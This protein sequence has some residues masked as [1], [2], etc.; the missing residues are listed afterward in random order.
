[1]M[2]SQKQHAEVKPEHKSRRKPEPVDAGLLQTDNVSVSGETV[3]GVMDGRVEN[4]AAWLRNK[5]VQAVQ[6]TSLA[7]YIGH[8]QGNRHLRGVVARVATGKG[9]PQHVQRSPLSD[10]LT[11]IWTNQPKGIFFNR[12]RNLNV[13]DPDVLSA[14][15][16][17]LSG[18]DLWLARNLINYGPEASWPIHL[19]VEREMK[20]WADCRGKGEVFSILR[21]AAGAEASN[22]D[23]TAVLNRIFPAGSDDLWLASNLQ[24]HGLEASWPIHLR[25]EREMKGWADC[26]GKGEVFTILRNAAGADSGNA[27]L[28]AVL[29]RIFTAGSDDLWVA[30]NLQQYG[31][32]ANWPIHLRVDR[33]MKGWAD[34]HGKGEV[35]TILRNAAGAEAGNADLTSTLDRLFAAGSEDRIL[36]N[37]LQQYG[38][39]ASWPAPTA[40]DVIPFDR[41]PNSSPGERIIMS[42]EY[43]FPLADNYHKLVYSCVGGGFDAAGGANNKTIQGLEAINQNFFIDAAWTGASPVTVTLQV[44][45]RSNNH[46]ALSETWT[47]AK[48]ARFPTTINQ[49]EAEG[50]RAL[51]STYSYKVGPDLGGDL[52]TDYEHQTILERFEHRTC[53]I[54]MDDLKWSFKFSHREIQSDQDICD[55]FFGTSSSN[56]TFAVDATDQIY[57]QHTG[58]LPSL[59]T[60]TNALSV[61]K[62]VY[63]DLPQIYEA[64]PGVTLG[65]YTIRRILKTSGDMKLKK[66][67]V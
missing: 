3:S 27:D 64:Q 67:K 4:Q 29:N 18:E 63:V 65:R 28:T 33:E 13:S 52:V 58:G 5:Q 2:S 34:S 44:Q 31:V 49:I 16:G 20:G 46:V 15:E 1:M 10:E 62:D 54:T 57:D 26:H 50:E 32:E 35:F 47:F 24:Q 17:M 11:E 51:G 39:E 9:K 56:G 23:L 30:Q 42:A 41:N 66:M 55:H 7:S 40:G 61:M 45:C 53:N 22:A 14:V 6:R 19:R 25:V 37:I 12:L 59:A 48:S 43:T 8:T 21:T 36:A 60:F 38:P